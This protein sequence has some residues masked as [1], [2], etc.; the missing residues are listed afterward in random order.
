MTSQTITLTIAGLTITVTVETPAIPAVS[1]APVASVTTA[2]VSDTRTPI[3]HSSVIASVGYNVIHR[4][5]EIE[6]R[7]GDV[8]QYD[9]VP[10]YIYDELIETRSAGQYFSYYI[11]DKYTTR[12]ITR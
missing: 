10:S 3:P 5:L 6:F 4:T 1:D 9:N 2:F 8:Y 7:S 11:R 12:K